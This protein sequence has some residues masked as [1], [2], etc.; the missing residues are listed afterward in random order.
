MR[1]AIIGA[2]INGACT[3]FELAHGGH[4]VSIFERDTA[5]AHTSR[6][7][8]KL[9]HGG[10]RYLENGEFGFV[11]EALLERR[12]WLNDAPQFA[13][14]LQLTLPIYRAARRPTW[15]VGLGLHVYDVLALGS[16][17]PR[18]KWQSRETTLAMNPTLKSDGLLGAFTFWD[19]QMDDKQL[20]QWVVNQALKAGAHLHEN[21]QVNSVSETGQ[22]NFANGTTKQFDQIVNAA[23]PWAASLLKRSNI[24]SKHDLDL[25]R[26]SHIVLDRLC[27][28]AFL[29][30]VPNERRIFFTLPWKGQTLV[31]T[32]EVRQV[33]ATEPSASMEEI[34][35]LLSSYNYF[36]NRPATVSDISETFSGLRPLVK[37]ATNPNQ[38]T[39]E[40]AFERQGRLL[41][42]FGGK[43][44]T[45]RALARNAKQ[46]IEKT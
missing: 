29:L 31:G 39:R 10:L 12:S 38:A 37:S 4:H 26:G 35:H 43:W 17:L 41:T 23:G 36:F 15:L 7:S 14:P 42:V 22:I 45:A 3:A 11:R 21:T 8:T 32:T 40:Y 25:V 5:M 34:V 30:E 18:H 6:S 44:T 2:G 33:D 19:G 13:K 24:A 46:M 9:L 20:G 28:S 16:G 1:I 27:S